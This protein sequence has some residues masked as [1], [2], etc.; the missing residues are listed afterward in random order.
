[1]F[2]MLRG[3]LM[4]SSRALRRL[5]LSSS[6]TIS[7]SAV[8][9]LPLYCFDCALCS[10]NSKSIIRILATWILKTFVT[11]CMT[12]NKQPSVERSTG[13]YAAFVY[14]HTD[15]CLKIQPRPDINTTDHSNPTRQTGKNKQTK[16]AAP[17]IQLPL[18][19]ANLA[20]CQKTTYTSNPTTQLLRPTSQSSNLTIG[21]HRHTKTPHV[22][23]Q[24]R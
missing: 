20:A 2:V 1:M 10:D 11:P 18:C 23:A 22:H 16:Q 24:P 9:Q 17:N 7:I 14:P 21:D 5:R 12:M 3:S 4:R 8:Y 15:F 19:S 13:R 6:L